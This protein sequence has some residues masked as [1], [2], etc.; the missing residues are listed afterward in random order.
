MIIINERIPRVFEEIRKKH[1]TRKERR[2]KKKASKKKVERKKFI[3]KKG[4]KRERKKERKKEVSRIQWPWE[5]RKSY[6][7]EEGNTERK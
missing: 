3:Y 1:L 2:K 7:E 6:T 4:G 5:E